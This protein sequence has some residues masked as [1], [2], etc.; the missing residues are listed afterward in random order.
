MSYS[1]D[2]KK[3]LLANCLGILADTI[4]SSGRRYFELNDG[5]AEYLVLDEE[6]RDEELQ[7]NIKET[8]SYFVP[9]FL[10][11]ETELPVEVFKALV[12]KN[13]AVYKL[14]EK[15]V[16]GGFE[17]FCEDAV[18]ADGYGHFLSGYDGEELELT[19]DLFAY[20]TN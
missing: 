1:L 4:S 13:E 8:C 10:A 2:D 17:Q 9:E 11:E 5:S 19:D 15:C 3:N 12:D 14:L 7:D 6:E 16:D 20:R 18:N